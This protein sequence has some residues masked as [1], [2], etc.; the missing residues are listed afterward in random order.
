MLSTVR[1]F[2][3]VDVQE[4]GSGRGRGQDAGRVRRA[5]AAVRQCHQCDNVTRRDGGPRD[6]HERRSAAEST[7]GNGDLLPHGDRGEGGPATWAVP[8]HAYFVR[9]AQGWRGVGFERVPGRNPPRI[10]A[11]G[12][13]LAA[14]R[15]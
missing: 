14:N 15:E 13:E 1:R 2:P 8:V 7:G 10:G 12:P 9:E 3:Y 5:L 4:R 11:G 6:G